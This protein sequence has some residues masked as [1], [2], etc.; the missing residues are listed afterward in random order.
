MSLPSLL[1]EMSREVAAGTH[2]AFAYIYYLILL[3]LE[4][5]DYS[6]VGVIS[7]ILWEVKAFQKKSLSSCTRKTRHRARLPGSESLLCHLTAV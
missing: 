4:C 2:R 6:E 3:R 5:R 1:E 7:P